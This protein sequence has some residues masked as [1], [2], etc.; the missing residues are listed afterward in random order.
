MCYHVCWST[1][2]K[3]AFV[4]HPTRQAAEHAAR[5]L[6]RPGE[7]YFIEKGRH[8]VRFPLLR[9]SRAK[10]EVGGSNLPSSGKRKRLTQALA[11]DDNPAEYGRSS[12]TVHFFC[13]M[14]GC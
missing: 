3:L 1:K 11:V 9:T 2:T 10:T 4:C 13:Q 5:A 6:V 12:G 8:A 14:R 7:T